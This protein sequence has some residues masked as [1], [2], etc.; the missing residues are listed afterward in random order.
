[1]KKLFIVLVIPFVIFSCK[2]KQYSALQIQRNK[3]ESFFHQG[4]LIIYDNYPILTVKGTPYEAGL[5]YGV[6]L[7]KQLV[8]M[9]NTVDSLLDTYIGSFFVKK[10]LTN[11]VL[12]VKIKRIEEKVPNEYIQE[13][14]GIT[15]G[16]E[17]NLRDIKLIA[18]FPQ[19][20]FK[21]SCTSFIMKDESKIVHG[22][23][24]DWPGFD[25]IAKHPLIVNYIIDGKNTFTNL[26]FIGYPG[27]Y[28]GMN[29]NG[30]SIS[31]NM[32]GAPVDKGEK[33]KDYNIGMPLAY[34][35][36]SILEKANNLNDVDKLL[37]G[38][39]S[40][41]WFITV[42]SKID[43]TGAIY[44]LTRGKISK[45]EMKNN[46]LFVENLS[47]SQKGRYAYSPIWM[48]STSNIARESKMK[49]LNK[50]Y[51]DLDII[52]K[53]YKIIT[54]KEYYNYSNAPN[55]GYS[56]N[57]SITEKSC[58]MDNFENKIYFSYG[59]GLAACRKYLEYDIKSNSI[60]KFNDLNNECID[61]E[62][63]EMKK[64]LSWYRKNYGDKKKVNGKDINVI[65]KELDKY[66]LNP[67]Y[68]AFLLSKYYSEAKYFDMAKKYADEY[69][70]MYSEYFQPY[71]NKYSI[72][73]ANNEYEDAVI[74]LKEM[75]Q[76]ETLSPY[77]KYIAWQ[78]LIIMYDKIIENSPDNQDLS[79]RIDDLYSKIEKYIS[80]YL[81]DDRTKEEMGKINIIVDKYKNRNN[82]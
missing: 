66:K 38:Y 60:K 22:R 49:E 2:S 79:N 63:V 5:Q 20:F 51:R 64:Y 59:A 53:S 77:Y 31:I 6:L 65:V 69:M 4:S 41:S 58:I 82:D 80:Q 37:D 25:D 28:T 34:K 35:V 29:N 32:N 33:I 55:Y 1:M 70:E 74:V 54:N 24:L 42:G 30:L 15:D 8:D 16:S 57:N 71:Y 68:K 72:L 7:N 9:D 10:W 50:K 48:F 27:V 67:G 56:I 44:E 73:N 3:N 62:F 12:G 47:L 40:H 46:F 14:Q 17:L 52:N 21:I 45:I 18:Y 39:S 11:I 61:I 76:I 75:L 13:L 81:Y 36:R 78:Q 23:N 43:N 26:T 19:L